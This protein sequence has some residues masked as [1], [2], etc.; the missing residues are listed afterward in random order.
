MAGVVRHNLPC[1]PNPA[2]SYTNFHVETSVEVIS[3]RIFVGGLTE[4]V[5]LFLLIICWFF[6]F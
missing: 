3:N 2:I 6:F 5:S 1:P 4:N